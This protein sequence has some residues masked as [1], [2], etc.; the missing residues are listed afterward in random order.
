MTGP[1]P[2]VSP[3]VPG[4]DVRRGT[5][6]R[7]GFLVVRRA[8][9]ALLWVL[10]GL[11]VRGAERVPVQGAFILVA[12]HLHNLDPIV[13][14]ASCPRSVHFMAKRELFGVPVV[15]RVIRRVGAFPVDRGRMDRSA[16]RR[17]EA[18]LAQGVGL[19]MFPEGSRSRTG[20]LS[21]AMPGAGMLAI[22]SGVPIVPVA[23]TESDTL[24]L[25]GRGRGR[26]HRCVRVQIG[27]PF[28]LESPVDG[29][30]LGAAEASEQMMRK[31]AD[32]LPERY[33]GVYATPRQDPDTAGTARG[34]N[35]QEPPA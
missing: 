3:P 8:C 12:N 1:R 34:S 4:D 16:L 25:N 17:A 13:V 31:V 27:D 26:Y 29:S 9:Y 22:R 32:L 19:G 7:V 33:R 2:A 35:I 11:R 28:H 15:G 10:L 6:G 21:V 18:T 23:V 24:P 14:A 30:R 20:A 5:L